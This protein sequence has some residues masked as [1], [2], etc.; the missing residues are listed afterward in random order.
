MHDEPHHRVD[1]VVD[2]LVDD[3]VH[4]PDELP[5]PIER[6]VHRPW[7]R[8]V[9]AGIC[10]AASLPPWGF[11]PLAFVGVALLDR[12][13]AGAAWRSRLWRGTLV[14]W[15]LFFPTILWISQLTAPGYVIA[16]LF[17]GFLIGAACLLVPP[18]AGRGLALI[19]AWVLV[20][21]LRTAW[22]FGGVPLSLL[23]VGQV[24]GVLWPIARIGGVLG[25][26][27]ATVAVGVAVSAAFDRHHTKAAAF[28]GFA[29][30]LLGVAAVA[31]SGE[32]TGRTVDI[33]LVQGGGPQGTR[34]IDT[35]RRKVFER[36]LDASAEV[37]E[38]MDMVLWPENVVDTDADVQDAR[39]GRELQAL[40]R[41]LDAPLSV[42]TVEGVDEE[43]FRNSQQVLDAD[44]E[45]TDRYVKVQ[46]VPFGEWVPFRS[47]IE[48]V[49]PDTLAKRDATISHESGLLT[50]GDVPVATVISWEVFFGHRARSGVEAGGE[51]LYNPTN[52]STYTG[53]FVQTQQVASS[54]LRAIESGR[55]LVQV[56]PTG[57]SAYVSPSGEVFQRT[58]TRERAV[59]VRRD[60]P[61]RDGLTWYT[62][63]GDLP[64]RVLAVLLVAAGWGLD[65]L[66]R[67]RADAEAGD[68]PSLTPPAGA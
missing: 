68:E 26:A 65:R 3:L 47:W 23:A 14:G 42:G 36:H 19:G 29:I 25:I 13:L 10:L 41:R 24:A 55:W 18:H 30:V 50:I 52:G 56:A 6:F 1:A 64:V 49:A 8:A 45:W 61:L 40:A 31:P 58:G 20:E 57:F 53:T 60:V 2:E 59:E 67:R 54:R 43:S 44:G 34:A 38:G 17:F 33:A 37:P 22:P 32:P 28:A 62:R 21:S 35:D 5:G 11:W 66:A 51:L 12:L 9:A 46:R 39:E 48:K 7:V 16:S 63:A 15:T 27:A 4:P